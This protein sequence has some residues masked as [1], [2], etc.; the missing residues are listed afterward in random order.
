MSFRQHWKSVK[1]SAVEGDVIS[2]CRDNDTRTY[3]LFVNKGWRE[4]TLGH[5]VDRCMC[6]DLSFEDLQELAAT[7]KQA[8]DAHTPFLNY[9]EELNG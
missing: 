8:I 6:C 3:R 1:S 2:G 9:D 5:Q 7:L 4:A